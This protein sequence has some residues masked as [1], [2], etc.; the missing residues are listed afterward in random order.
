MPEAISDISPAHGLARVVGR[1]LQIATS[2]RGHAAVQG[3][4]EPVG[5]LLA[6]LFIKPFLTPLLLHYMLAFV[7][8]IMV[9]N[10]SYISL[11]CCH[12]IK[13]CVAPVGSLVTFY[14]PMEPLLTC[15][16]PLSHL[17]CHCYAC[18]CR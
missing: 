2:E 6:L 17:D 14:R 13:P 18:T 15:H 3:L 10:P 16:A 5:A 11:G 9:R 4:S 8:G 1:L 12:S 7:G